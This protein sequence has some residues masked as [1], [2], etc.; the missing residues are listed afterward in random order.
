ML[1][2]FPFWSFMFFGGDASLS[3]SLVQDGLTMKLITY[4][5][6]SDTVFGAYWKNIPIHPEYI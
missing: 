3:S 5:N 4:C 2:D 1:T 6:V